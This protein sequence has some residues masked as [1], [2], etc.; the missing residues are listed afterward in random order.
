MEDT[1]I[2]IITKKENIS[3]EL[4]NLIGC[5]RIDWGDDTSTDII[6][7]EELHSHTYLNIGE[8]N[9]ILHGLTSFG[10][11]FFNY[12]NKQWSEEL[13][14]TLEIYCGSLITSIQA[15]GMFCPNIINISLN[16]SIT[17]IDSFGITGAQIEKLIIPGSVSILKLYAIYGL[18]KLK[19]LIIEEGVKLL[20]Q[21]SIYFNPSLQEVR[22]PKNIE[23]IESNAFFSNASLL[24]IFV[25]SS[26]KRIE[27]YAFGNLTE[28]QNDDKYHYMLFH[29][30]T[31]AAKK[32]SAWDDEWNS[33]GGFWVN[34]GGLYVEYYNVRW[35]ANIIYSENYNYYE[36][37]GGIYI[38]K[39]NNY[40][41]ITTNSEDKN[42]LE[43]P[44]YINDKKVIGIEGFNFFD[45]SATRPD[46]NSNFKD[47]YD[48]IILPYSI[49]YIGT[50]NFSALS[51]LNNI[52]IRYEDNSLSEQNNC[53]TLPSNIKHIEDYSFVGLPNIKKIIIPKEVSD[54]IIGL[55]FIANG[56]IEAEIKGQIKNDL[57]FLE[58]CPI[59]PT[60][61][62]ESDPY[63][64]DKGWRK[65]NNSIF[66][67]RNSINADELIIPEDI[68]YIGSKTFNNC[69]I[70]TLIIPDT[71]KGF[72][73]AFD[74]SKII[75]LYLNNTIDYIG[76]YTFQEATIKNLYLGN[77]IKI[78]DSGA[79]D[80][81]NIENIYIDD[82]DTFLNI[83]FID[84]DSALLHSY[85]SYNSSTI[86]YPKLFVKNDLGEYELVT[87][88]TIKQDINNYSFYEYS[89]LTSL[90]IENSINIGKYAFYNCKNIKEINIKG[91]IRVNDNGLN[92]N[93]ESIIKINIDTK[94]NWYNSF[95][96]NENSLPS[97]NLFINNEELL[98]DNIDFNIRDFLYYN[99]NSLTDITINS[100]KIGKYA[101]CNCINLNNIIL[102]NEN[103]SKIGKKAFYNSYYYNNNIE[104]I[105]F[106]SPTSGLIDYNLRVIKINN[107][108]LYCIIDAIECNGIVTIG[109]TNFILI[110][111]SAFEDFKDTNFIFFFFSYIK[112]IG[113]DAFKNSSIGAFGIMDKS[114]RIIELREIGEYAFAN[115]QLTSIGALQYTN[116]SEDENKNEIEEPSVSPDITMGF[117]NFNLLNKIGK[118]A[119]YNTSI[120][121]VSIPSN[122]TYIDEHAFEISLMSSMSIN[123]GTVKPLDSWAIN[124]SP[125]WNTI[126]WGRFAIFYDERL[127][128]YYL[129]NRGAVLYK[130]N[131]GTE[132]I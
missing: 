13:D 122:I 4:Q 91:I 67:G 114:E 118:Y 99:C 83:T 62:E 14:F 25:P 75:N 132:D 107:T 47:I 125:S 79:F 21:C 59:F 66:G 115:S 121:E 93:N 15:Y 98:I 12:Q 45:L 96:E 127:S 69:N 128:Q 77:N 111:D 56:I 71:V 44:K 48:T 40:E 68:I 94:D 18:M 23:C 65:I 72:G 101:F 1:L 36:S 74:G 53:C 28:E 85:E 30:Y 31:D 103:I 81:S 105:E 63:L 104:K 87:N 58:E 126:L 29:I 50:Y 41:Q 106:H 76:K 102:T 49:Q 32:P 64:T 35:N 26:T 55:S 60:K 57:T 51:N 117:T 34:G 43:I 24:S 22:L 70:N 88:L 130:Y 78:I 113:N 46:Y 5:T 73:Y 52:L 38:Y 84:K 17:N 123:V 2:K 80:L 90:N 112:Y 92:L 119:F 109:D 39:I 42:I 27:K 97:Y 8:Y 19:Q 61:S 7:I 89:Y 16:N 110:A 54:L 100:E 131:P 20:E 82:I 6:N 95:V 124:W 9:I 10:Q 129:E 86:N 11:D 3:I 108:D 33:H 120:T 37:N 116:S